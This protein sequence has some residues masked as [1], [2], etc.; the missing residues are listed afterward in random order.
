MITSK[1]TF[2]ILKILFARY[3]LCETIVSD[4][5]PSFT[6]S[7][8]QNFLNSVGVQHMT[9]APYH[10]ASNGATESGVKIIKM[11]LKK[12]L[13]YNKSNDFYSVLS[14]FLMDYRNTNHSTTGVTPAFLMYGRNLT[15]RFSLLLPNRK[16]SKSRNLREVQ[17]RVKLKQKKQA[18]YYKNDRNVSFKVNKRVYYKNFLK[19]KFERGVILKQVGRCTYLIK[20]LN[21]KVKKM[22]TNQLLKDE[23]GSIPVFVEK[24][25]NDVNVNINVS[26]VK[27]KGNNGGRP[28]RTVRA[29]DR[30]NYDSIK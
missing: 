27:T 19:N 23:T 4:N 13:Y 24:D 8:F 9:I 25:E 20:S 29:P 14:Q 15:T 2:D 16:Q 3:G 21:G 6:S 11:A 18:K 17:T 10:P 12:A 5:A 28:K 26:D 30:L 7:K 22:H 1:F